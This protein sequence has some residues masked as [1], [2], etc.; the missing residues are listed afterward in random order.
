MVRLLHAAVVALLVAAMA[1]DKPETLEMKYED[2]VDGPLR[3]MDLDLTMVIDEEMKKLMTPEQLEDLENAAFQETIRQS[4]GDRESQ[5][6]RDQWESKDGIGRKE[7][8]RRKMTK[9]TRR[10]LEDHGLDCKGC[11][12]AE[13]ID[14]INDFVRREQKRIKSEEYY[15]ERK[16]RSWGLWCR[17]E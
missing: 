11:T 5:G 15:A 16:G 6:V 14:V 7:D 3:D 9:K 13:A 4:R 10:R 17:L 1:K 2:P 8:L 12:N